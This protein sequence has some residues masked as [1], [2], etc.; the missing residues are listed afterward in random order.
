MKNELKYLYV[1]EGKTDLQKLKDLGLEN[2]IITN[3]FLMVSQETKFIKHV[4]NRRKVIIITDPDGPGK[5]IANLIL[6]KLNEKEKESVIVVELDKKQSMKKGKVGLAQAEKE[7]LLNIL[8]DY[9]DHDKNIDE[10]RVNS[11]DL[12]DQGF[13]V[14]ERKKE[15]MRRYDF[16]SSGNKAFLNRLNCLGL[17]KEDLD[18]EKNG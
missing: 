9:I 4:L 14:F 13:L 8:K 5:R 15:M 17:T 3:G 16:V 10:V 6:E 1:V 12:V 2:I 11:N 18:Y 7:Y